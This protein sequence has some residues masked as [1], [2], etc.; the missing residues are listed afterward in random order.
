[1]RREM[2]KSVIKPKY[3]LISDDIAKF[4]K[5]GKEISIIKVLL[6]SR[7]G[8][9]PQN[10]SRWRA[11]FQKRRGYRTHSMMV[12][13]LEW[14]KGWRI[15]GWRLP[16]QECVLQFF[17]SSF[18]FLLNQK[19]AQDSPTCSDTIAQ[20]RSSDT[21]NMNWGECFA[22]HLLPSFGKRC[23]KFVIDGTMVRSTILQIL[24]LADS[25]GKTSTSSTICALCNFL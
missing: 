14:W 11:S 6:V 2:Q 17:R 9:H 4:S 15:H 24:I 22:P 16:P 19:Q 23:S 25:S 18:S 10:P 20:R 1:M 3:A 13:W 12:N 21:E 8:G 5:F 7:V